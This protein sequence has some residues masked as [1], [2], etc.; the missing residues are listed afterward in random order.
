[1]A[2]DREEFTTR[3]TTYVD[4]NTIRKASALPKHLPD[5]QEEIIRR[6]K[7]QR[8][9]RRVR[10]I[11]APFALFLVAVSIVTLVLCVN[12]LKM[13][14]E[15]SNRVRNIASLEKQLDTIHTQN[16]SIDYSINSYVDLEHIYQVA[17]EELG[18]VRA[19]KSQ[20]SLYEHTNS[21]FIKQHR[22]IPSVK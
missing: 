12:Y 6:E 2:R 9:Q 22:D 8:N 15:I 20:V 11:N 19:T 13:Q 17:T 4:G 7:Y 14:S 10:N 21:E 1:M 5:K 16:N 18:M 3:Y